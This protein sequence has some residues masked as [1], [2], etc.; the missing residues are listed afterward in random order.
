MKMQPNLRWS[1][2]SLA[3]AYIPNSFSG[4]DLAQRLVINAFAN[5]NTV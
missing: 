5:I 2:E 1:E 4:Q 3:A